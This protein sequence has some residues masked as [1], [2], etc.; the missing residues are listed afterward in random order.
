MCDPRG[1]PHLRNA[2]ATI[3]PSAVKQASPEQQLSDLM[4]ADL[5]TTC[6]A[7]EVRMFVRANWRKITRFAHAIHDSGEPTETPTKGEE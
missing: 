4:R 2:P 5:G 3:T 1:D 7:R 6:S